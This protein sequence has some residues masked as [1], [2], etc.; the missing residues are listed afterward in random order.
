ML[1]LKCLSPTAGLALAVALGLGLA[2]GAQAAPDE[3]LLGRDRG[4]AV[5]QGNWYYDE[6]VRVGSFTHQAEIAGLFGGHANVLKP[7]AKPMPLAS[8]AR[9]PDYRWTV[10]ADK[11]LTVDSLLQRQRIM[12]LLIVK[13]GVIQVERYQYGRQAAHRFTSNSMAKSIT[14]LGIG[15]AL[16]EGRIRS[17]DDR[18]ETYATALRGSVYGSTRLRDLLHMAAGAR[19]DQRNE[20]AG[21]TA[22]FGSAVA[23]EGVEAAARLITERETEDG[24]RFHYTS[25]QTAVLGAVLRGATGM[26]LSD[27]LGPR[28]WQAMGAETSVLWRAD[29]TGLEV[30]YGNFNAT[31]RDYARLGIVLANDGLRPD[32]AAAKPIIAREFLLDASDGKRQPQGFAP[33]QATPTYGYGYQFWILPGERRRFVMLGVYGQSIFIDPGQR[34]VIVQTGANRTPDAGQTS[35]ARERDAFWRGVVRH[36]GAW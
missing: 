36:Y 29:R 26:S 15:I 20:W 33:G 16:G 1:C 4:Y 14:A 17:L 25:S 35:L 12:G 18:A 28:L 30:A 11:A 27:Y 22:R 8:A 24:R 31:L 6:S 21:D 2:T 13:D 3:V 19:Y 23:R 32:D 9:E 7:A 10:G 34:L 5:G